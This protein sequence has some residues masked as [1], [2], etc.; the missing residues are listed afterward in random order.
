MPKLTARAA[1]LPGRDADLRPARHR[2]Q[3][4]PR[5]RSARLAQVRRLS[6][7]RADRVA[8]RHRR[9]HRALRRQEEPGGDD[10]Q[11]QPRGGEAGRHAAP[12]AQPGRH[13]RHRLHRHGVGR[14]PGPGVR[15][16][17]AG[18]ARRQGAHQH[19]AHL[20]AGAG[21][22][23]AQ[24]DAREPGTAREHAVPALRGGGTRAL[25][26]DPRLRGA[27]PGA[28]RG[29][30]PRRQRPPG[31]ACAPRRRRV[32]RGRGRGEPGRA[33]GADRSRGHGRVRS[34]TSRPATSR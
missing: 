1:P 19:P 8:H 33:R 23:D 16:P 25:R 2:D 4:R 32:S 26:R 10:P 7:H 18:D 24:A 29:R 27:P 12:P 6:H 13:H 9:Q 11:D 31:A 17:A 5:A 21:R 3:D 28:A 30:D 22:D 15:G 34:A 20:R 14:E